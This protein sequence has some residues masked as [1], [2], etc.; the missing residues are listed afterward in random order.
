MQGVLLEN[1]CTLLLT[2]QLELEIFIQNLY[3]CREIPVRNDEWS[4][5]SSQDECDLRVYQFEVIYEL[6]LMVMILMNDHPK[7]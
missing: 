4:S 3:T 1:Y 2:I 6:V 5:A 7:S